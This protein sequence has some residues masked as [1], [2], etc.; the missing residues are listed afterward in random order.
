MNDSVVLRRNK[1]RIVCVCEM[2]FFEKLQT[3]IM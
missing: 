1:A 2:M 3:T